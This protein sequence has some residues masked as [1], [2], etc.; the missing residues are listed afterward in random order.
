MEDA[1]RYGRKHNRKPPVRQSSAESSALN[2]PGLLSKMVGTH[3]RRG[4]HG[5][6]SLII[7]SDWDGVI[8]GTVR[9]PIRLK[10]HLFVSQ[11]RPHFQQQ[12]LNS[13]PA[14]M[15]FESELNIE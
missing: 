12:Y 8:D 14:L 4:P 7:V 2:T 3:R 6:P 5:R 11:V 9:P 1:Y 13:L 15:F 10:R